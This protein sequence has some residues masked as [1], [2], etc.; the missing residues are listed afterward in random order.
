MSDWIEEHRSALALAAG[1]LVCSVFGLWAWLE[2]VGPLPGERGV[3]AWQEHRTFSSDLRSLLGFF[4]AFGSPLVAIAVVGSVVAVVADQR[5]V[6]W[7]VL[8]L[9]ASAVVVLTTALKA[10]FGPTPL[11]ETA[12]ATSN[13]PSGHTAF[14]TSL[15]GLLAVMA[16]GGG[17][18]IAAG[19]LAAW[20]A[21]MGPAMVVRGAHLPS[22]VLSGYAVGIAWLITVVLIGGRWAGVSDRARRW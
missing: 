8:V 21:A 13:F 7:A 11:W 17:S 19:V 18:R 14:A 22:D 9:A 20:A 2:V 16:R 6:R 10:M 12:H 15:L 5:G 1:A 4:L 3:L